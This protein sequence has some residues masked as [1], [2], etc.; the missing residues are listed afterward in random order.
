MKTSTKRDKHGKRTRAQLGIPFR[1]EAK[2]DAWFDMAE[3]L[4]MA[5]TAT[6]L[7]RQVLEEF[8]AA[9]LAP[10]RLRDIGMKKHLFNTGTLLRMA[11]KNLDDPER[12]ARVE[13]ERE[14]ER[15][16]IKKIR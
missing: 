9:N 8:M 3:Q 6:D 14:R 13:E 12:Q 11:V 16:V 15:Q 7:A 2:R 5:E 1:P 4:A 10:E